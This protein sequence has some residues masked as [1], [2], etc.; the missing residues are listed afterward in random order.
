MKVIMHLKVSLAHQR[1]KLE[2]FIPCR[3]HG[4]SL[5]CQQLVSKQELKALFQLYCLDKMLNIFAWR[6]VIFQLTFFKCSSL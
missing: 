5:K 3:N 6:G 4:L 1:R 2:H